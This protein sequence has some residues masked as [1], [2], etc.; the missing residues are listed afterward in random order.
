MSPVKLTTVL[1]NQVGDIHMAKVLRDG[2]LLIVCRSEEQRQLAGRMKEMGRNKVA[3]TN[4]IE[5]GTKW[6]KGVIWG[7]PVSLTMD[8]IKANLKGGSVK[9]VRRLQVNREGVRVDSESILVEFE[10]EVLPKKVTLG[11]MSYNVREYVPT[12]MRCYNC[13]RFGHTAKTCKGRRRCAR[14]G[15][16]HDYEQCSHK[17]QPRC[18]NCGGNHT[19]AYGGCEVLKRE[20][21]IQQVRIQGKMTYAEAVRIVNQ[22]GGN[23][24]ISSEVNKTLIN[25]NILIRNVSPRNRLLLFLTPTHR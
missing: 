15:E 9:G 8:E 23:G 13:Q 24:E 20:K 18:C 7:V 22:R 2:N 3:S 14:C 25:M 1:T 4:Y 5:R 11:F 6:C 10:D 16:D 21:E 17:E 12:P 19:V